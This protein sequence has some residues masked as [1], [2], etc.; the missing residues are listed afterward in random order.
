M[1][2]LKKNRISLKKM[3]KENKTNCYRNFNRSYS[4]FYVNTYL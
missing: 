1:V 3:F 2:T 4:Q